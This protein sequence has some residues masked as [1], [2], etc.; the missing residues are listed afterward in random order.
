VR[1]SDDVWV[2]D[3]GSSDATRDIATRAGARVIVRPLSCGQELFGG[4]E[5]EHKNWALDN[6]PFR[7]PWVLHLDADERVTPELATSILR[8]IQNPSDKVAFR[9]KRRDFWRNQWLKH[10]VTSSFYIRLFRPNFMRYDRLVNPLSLPNGPIGELQGYLDHYPFSKGL[11][12]WLNKHNAYSSLEAQQIEQNRAANRRFSVK[13]ALFGKDRNH[14]RFHQK[15]LFYRIPGRPLIKFVLLYVGKRGF[16]DG[17]AGFRYAV[18][19]SI[20]EYLIVLKTNELVTT[21]KFCEAVSLSPPDL[22]A[23]LRGDSGSDNQLLTRS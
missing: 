3:S 4:N 2:Y 22:L 14:R 19:Q 10:V 16:L 7:Y 8:A 11:A 5:A 23:G 17:V 13:E 21:P 12:P 9:V 18:L 1:W 15:E 6:I 20:Y